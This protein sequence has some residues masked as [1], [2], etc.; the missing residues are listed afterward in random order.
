MTLYDTIGAGYA[1][2]RRPDPRIGAAIAA[3]LGEAGSVVNVGA[4]AGSYEPV[5]TLVA[6]EPSRV[7]IDQRPAGSAPVVQGV[8]EALPLADDCVDAALAVLT[9]HHWSDLAAGLAE[10]RRVARRRLVFLHWRPELFDSFWLTAEYLPAAAGT[11]AAM[12][13]PVPELLERLPG[14]RVRVDPVPVPHDCVDGFAAAYWRRPEAYLDPRVRA[15]ISMLARTPAPE[16]RSGLTRLAED[17]R[18]GRWHAEHAALLVLDSLDLGY[19][20]VTVDL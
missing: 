4:G 19:C 1:S 5:T 20:T 6:V 12:A 13:V 8:A 7:M 16:L 15:G 17:V 3:A 9:L 14:C 18:S 2:R 11:D 10:L